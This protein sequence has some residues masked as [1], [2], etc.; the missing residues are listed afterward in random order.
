M[1]AVLLVFIALLS[2]TPAYAQSGTGEIWGRVTAV[3]GEVIEGAAVTVTNV[4]TAANRETHTDGS[5]RFGFAAVPAGRYQVTATHDG[6]AGRRQDD[7]VLLPGQRMQTELPLRRAVM[8]ETIALN[9]YPPI[10]ESARTHASAFVAEA[11]IEHLPI[12]GRR[13]LRLAELAPAVTEDAATG[14]LSVMDLPSAQNRVVIDG[15][16]HTS[17]ITGDPVGREGPSRVPYQLSQWSVDAFR[18]QTNGAPAENGRAGA[19]VI[20]VVTRS[21]ANAFHGSGY[22]FFGDRVMTGKKA[23]DERAGLHKPPYRS[24]Q[25]GAVV[26]GPIVKEHNFFLV[27]YD[28]LRRTDGPTASP[29]LTPFAAAGPAALAPLQSALTRDARDQQ[30]DV[31]F[32]RTDHEYLRQHLTLRYVDQLFNGRAIDASPD[33]PAIPSDGRS[34][35]RTRAGTGLLASVIGSALVNEARVQYADSRDAERAATAPGAVVFD[36][37]SFVAQTGSSLFGPH[38]FATKRLQMADSLSWVRGAHS[39][40]AGGD[41]LKDRNATR[42]GA[43]T[44]FG[45]PS[46]AAFAARVPDA[47]TQTLPTSEVHADADQYAVFVQ[48]AWRASHALTIDLGIRYDLQDFHD[49]VARDRNDWAPRVGFAFAPGER[50][51]VFRAAYGLFYGT[52]PALIPALA[53]A[54]DGS[55][56][57][58]LPA[59]MAVVDPSFKTARVHQATAGWEIEKYRAGSLGIDYLFARGERLPRS[60]DINVGGRFPGVGRVVSF[61]SSGQSLYNGITAHARARVLQQLFYTIAYTFA[62]SDE[63]PQEPIAMVFGGTNDRR[64]L[65][66]QGSV[67]DVR[68]PGNNDQHHHLTL[69]AMYDTSLLAVDRHGLSKRLIGNWEWGLVWTLQSGQPYSAFVRGDINGDHNALNDL[70]PDTTRN[71]YR[72]P[73]RMSVDPRVARRIQFGRTRQLHVIWEAYNLSNRPNYTSVDNTLFWLDGSS[74]VRNPLFGRKTGQADARVMQL[75]AR[76]TF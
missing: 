34:S 37:P 51:N 13:Y 5:G 73:T 10:G 50:K 30:Q 66:M 72:L 16:D 40:K 76:L 25:F 61:E 53:Q 36:G 12:A 39:L 38:A 27:S 67:L 31:I 65:A 24:N 41:V 68:A 33:Q 21:G 59:A 17:G 75:A 58:V 69:S 54:Y 11:E 2:F 56:V 3:T 23:L 19:S 1:T 52:T 7:I 62:R 18:I 22:E 60:I 35:L 55:P 49:V 57:R 9:P 43:Q 15:F 70:A 64:S 47:V 20:N 28:G 71:Q 74:L 4:E 14:G 32:A 8:P 48:D 44:T 26:G 6:F 46:I 42:F 63:T 29:N 45:F